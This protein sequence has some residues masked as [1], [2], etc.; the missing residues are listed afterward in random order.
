M[1]FKNFINNVGLKTKEHVPEILMIFGIGG[2]VTGGV[3]ACRATYK[4]LPQKKELH[5]SN[6]EN[7][8]ELYQGE[9][10]AAAKKETKKEIARYSVDLVKIYA[11]PVTVEL[12]GVSMILASNYIMRKRVA[13]I[14]AAFTTVSAAYETYRERVRERFGEEVD[15][16]ILLGEKEVE[17]EKEDEN[18][19]I[20]KETI[21]V[22]DPDI[23]SI[24]RY[25][26][27]KNGNF[28]KSNTFMDDVVR[29][30]DAYLTDKLKAKGY[31]T[32][33]DIYEEWDFDEDTEA[34]MVVGKVY[35][36]SSDDNY[37]QTRY[38]K[39]NI[40]D[41]FGNYEEAWYLDWDGLEIIYG[42]GAGHRSI[43][44]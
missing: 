24:G 11:I 2:M 7:I 41:E 18:G 8:Q 3:L 38:V 21:T 34:G 1:S 30:K 43:A 26:T 13:G 36:P 19:E 28:S 16:A 33:N 39:K 10:D 15:Q 31:I 35:D 4:K 23:S 14:T 25:L 27:E 32:V 42:K 9:D 20:V 40:P 29:M 6:L 44:H 12:T 22:A 5:E 17:I 37:I